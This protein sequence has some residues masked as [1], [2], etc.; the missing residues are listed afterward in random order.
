MI[1]DKTKKTTRRFK[2]NKKLRE[3]NGFGGGP[4]RE[5]KILKDVVEL[6]E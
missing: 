1:R 5:K 6:R 3:T 2:E 4:R